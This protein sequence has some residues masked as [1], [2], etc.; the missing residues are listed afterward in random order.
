MDTYLHARHDKNILQKAQETNEELLIGQYYQHAFSQDVREE[1]EART[2]R[3]LC[4]HLSERSHLISNIDL[5]TIS[6][7]CRNCLAKVSRILA[8]NHWEVLTKYCRTQILSFLI[9]YNI[10]STLKW[11]VL[12]ARNYSKEISSNP[13]LQQTLDSFGYDEAAEEI[14]G[15]AYSEWKKNYASKATDEQ[16]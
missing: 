9:Y 3:C 14:Y 16:M 6:G 12:A 1:M 8:F 13:D 11:L 2:F 15:C 10:V 5:M 4:Q 7:F